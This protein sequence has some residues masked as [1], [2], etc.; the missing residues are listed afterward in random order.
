LAAGKI[1]AEQTDIRTE[2]SQKAAI[3]RH[4]FVFQIIGG[5]VSLEAQDAMMLI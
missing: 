5:G 1:V 4:E 2:S 3:L